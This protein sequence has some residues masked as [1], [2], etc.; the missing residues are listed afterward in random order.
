MAANLGAHEVMEIH[1]TLTF[2][3]DGINHF[4]LYRPYVRDQHLL[5][6]LDHQ[7]QFMTNEYNGLVQ[8]LQQQGTGQQTAYR[9]VKNVQPKYGLDNPPNL[10]PNMSPDQLDDRD[11]ASGMLSCHKAS[12][13]VKM[14]GALECADPQIR[15]AIQQSAVNC[16]EQA[17]EVWQYMNRQGFYQVPTMKEMTTNTLMHHYEMAG[18][19]Q[20]Q[21]P[22]TGSTQQNAAG[23]GVQ[24]TAQGAGAGAAAGMQQ[25]GGGMSQQQSAVAAPG[26]QQNASGGGSQND[27]PSELNQTAGYTSP[28][29]Q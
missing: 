5:Q 10:S 24:H 23:M 3:I 29:T 11:V 17:Y 25:H 9:S 28:L 4:Q 2:T 12:A 22:V 1:E 7:L 18:G 19:V 6:M 14:K 13:A 16:A 26:L 27:S 8:L 20:Q 21:Q 15:R